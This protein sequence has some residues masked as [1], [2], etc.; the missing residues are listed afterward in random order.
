[1]DYYGGKKL[2][3][4]YI[5]RAQQ[6]VCVMIDK[7][8]SWHVAAKV[9]NDTRSAVAGTYVVRDGDS[10]ETLLAGTFEVPAGATAELG[11]IR[12]PY[13]AQKLL[14]IEWEVGGVRCGNHYVMG[15]PAFS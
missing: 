6:P 2:A 1:V 10:G 7:P 8:E 4:Y 15:S 12:A 5:R 13:S 14:L 9:S 11:R 3:Y